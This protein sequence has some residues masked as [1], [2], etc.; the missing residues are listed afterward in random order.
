MN[1][2]KLKLTPV[3]SAPRPMLNLMGYEELHELRAVDVR[4]SPILPIVVLGLEIPLTQDETSVH[5]YGLS[6]PA[7]ARL[8]R[9]L[10]KAVQENLYGSDEQ[11]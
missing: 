8:A 2:P 7:A 5:R 10:D 3:P 6:L 9:M 1:E 11:E 4:Q